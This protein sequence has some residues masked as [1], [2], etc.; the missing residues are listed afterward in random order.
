MSGFISLLGW[1][2]LPQFVTGWLQSIYYSLTIRAGSPHPQPG[3]QR[4]VTHRRAIHA[5]VVVAYLLYTL[6]EADYDLRRQGNFYTD[7]GL[8]SLAAEDREIKS[9]FRRLATIYH[10]DKAG[11]GA[12]ASGNRFIHLKL[13][14]ETLLDPAARFAYDR[15]GPDITAWRHASTVR[16]YLARGVFQST[17]PHYGVAAVFLYGFGLLGY[18]NWGRYWRWVLLASLCVFECHVVTRPHHPAVLTALNTALASLIGKAPY[19]PFQLITMMRK[20]SIAL[21]IAFNQLGPSFEYWFRSVG[22]DE[23]ADDVGE[24]VLLR[25]LE[26][27][28]SMVQALQSDTARLLDREMAPFSDDPEALTSVRTKVKDWL[29]QNTIRADPMVRDAVETSV[30]R[31]KNRAVEG[32]GK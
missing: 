30:R 27:L 31:R 15:F 5:L 13:A 14:S 24:E 4:Y 7:L 12:D 21:Y 19:L 2:F 28:D 23:A 10:P 29:V 32:D 26:R 3:S 22:G 6:Y 16:D 1:S 18:L 20:A 25:G 17:L 9:R 11:A 8:T